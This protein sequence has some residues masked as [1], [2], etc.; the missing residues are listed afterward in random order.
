MPRR[1]QGPIAS[2]VTSRER[3]IEQVDVDQDVSKINQQWEEEMAALRAEPREAV[4][5]IR[6]RLVADLR[7]IAVDIADDWAELSLVA[8]AGSGAVA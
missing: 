3:W 7:R 6:D 5:D 4:D 8:L 1:D 2:A